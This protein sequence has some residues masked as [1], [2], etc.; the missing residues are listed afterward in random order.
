[1]ADRSAAGMTTEAAK[2][3]RARNV[4]LGLA[5]GAL[6]VLFYVLTIAK[7]GPQVLNRPI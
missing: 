3:R 7:L 4:A 6:V 1:M 2:R 5:L